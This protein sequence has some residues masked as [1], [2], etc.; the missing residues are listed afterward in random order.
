MAVSF[1]TQ[2]CQAGSCALKLCRALRGMVLAPALPAYG[3]DRFLNRTNCLRSTGLQRDTLETSLRNS[4]S[5]KTKVRGS[6]CSEK[7]LPVNS[8]NRFQSSEE[9]FYGSILGPIQPCRKTEIVTEIERQVSEVMKDPGDGD[10]DYCLQQARFHPYRGIVREQIVK[11]SPLSVEACNP[12]TRRAEGLHESAK[13]AAASL[14]NRAKVLA[15]RRKAMVKL[16]YKRGI[17]GFDS[18]ETGKSG[19][20]EK[21]YREHQQIVEKQREKDL[22]RR[23]AL[24]ERSFSGDLF[25]SG[26]G[27]AQPIEG[28]GRFS[29][30]FPQKKRV[31]PTGEAY[32]VS[33]HDK[34]FNRTRVLELELG[35]KKRVSHEDSNVTKD[36][37]IVSH[38][39]RSSAANRRA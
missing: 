34:L 8:L 30:L 33:S 23:R 21:E 36:F 14:I 35:R 15:S 4:K 11:V 31:F 19:F 9:P 28:N 39:Q 25:G 18:P 3:L 6:A 2:G 20:Y 38:C 27:S 1:C 32:M 7:G 5:C 26:H 16:H 37:D 29:K 10:F 13:A 22:R 17:L 24:L 12:K